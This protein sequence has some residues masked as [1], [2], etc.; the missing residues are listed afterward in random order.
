[1]IGPQKELPGIAIA[2][3]PFYFLLLVGE[4]HRVKED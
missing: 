1:V 4:D 2:E 3:S